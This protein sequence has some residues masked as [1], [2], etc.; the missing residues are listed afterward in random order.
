[1]EQKSPFGDSDSVR[2]IRSASLRF[3][4]LSI[5]LANLVFGDDQSSLAIHVTVSLVYLAISVAS[6][7]AATHFPKR[8]GLKAAFVA[9]D[10]ALV[11]IVLYE[12]ILASPITDNHNLTTSSLVVAFI[13]LNHVAL[14]LD[15]GLIVLFSTTVVA[16][17]VIMLAIMA[18]R[19]HANAPG[20]LLSSFFNQDL[21]LTIS[22]GFTAFAVYLLA[23]DYDRTMRQAIKIEERRLNLSRFFSPTVVSDLQEASAI[24]DLERRKA[25]VMFVDIRDFTSY[26]EVATAR[27]LARVLGEYRRIVAGT[28]FAYGG[29][30]DKF[31]GDGV[32]AVFGQPRPRPDDAH[33]ALACALELAGA[34]E[35][36]R[37]AN[38]RKGGPFL[39]AGIG[40][41]YGTVIGGVLES[42][43]H[44]EFTV[45]GDP[46]N[47]AQRLEALAKS[48]KTP[49]V[50]SEALLREVPAEAHNSRWFRRTNVK[51]PGRRETIDVAFMRSSM[52][53]PLDIPPAHEIGER[54]TDSQRSS[55]QSVPLAP[56]CGK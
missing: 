49:L 6:V 48:L 56:L 53:E 54:Q 55:F 35:Q 4:A 19:H 5:L 22:F 46:V 44:D 23:W 43:F 16:S 29:T 52:A 37:I 34:L 27:E 39:E 12:H 1:M 28:V 50:V 20:A 51:L 31:I 47:V 15:R 2:E 13:L 10:A 17:W 24:L 7:I 30:V 21:A 32:M 40:L 26:A 11:A 18:Y 45:V 41:H 9:L 3:V 14:K 25:A 8:Q 36:W 42:G 33:R 38:V